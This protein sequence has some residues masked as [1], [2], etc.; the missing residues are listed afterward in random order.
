MKDTPNSGIDKYR[1]RHPTLGDS[2]AG[3]NFGY[4]EIGELRIIASDG[5]CGEKWEHVS[6]SLADRTPTWDELCLVKDLFW[7]PEETVIQIH[8]PR[9]KHINFHNFCLHLWRLRG[10]KQP[11]PPMGLIG[12]K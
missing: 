4:F 8:P 9:S 5:Q 10:F 12:P 7:G 3:C 2:D 6:V 11:L 1:R